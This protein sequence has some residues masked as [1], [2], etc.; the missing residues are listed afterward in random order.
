MALAMGTG[1]APRFLMVLTV[2]VASAG[3]LLDA[4]VGDRNES[5]KRVGQVRTHDNR[6]ARQIG[7]NYG[8][9]LQCSS[10]RFSVTDL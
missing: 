6:F 8:T 4:P 2:T 9:D 5:G 3:A 7:S 10:G 1:H